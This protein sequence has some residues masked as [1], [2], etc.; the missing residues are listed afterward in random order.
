MLIGYIPSTVISMLSSHI[1]PT[2]L[3]AI[4]NRGILEVRDMPG[5]EQ[6]PT[7]IMLHGL[8]VTGDLNWHKHYELLTKY[9]RVVVYDHHGHGSGI[10]LKKKFTL[11]DAADDVLGVANALEIDKFTPV[12][13]SMGGAVAQLV[14]YRHPERVRGMVLAATSTNFVNGLYG[15]RAFLLLRSFASLAMYSPKIVSDAFVHKVYGRTLP[16]NLDPWVLSQLLNHDW[17]TVAWAGASIGRYDSSTFLDKVT[18]RSAVLV[19]TKDSVVRADDQEHLFALL[20]GDKKMF[21]I[22]GDH[23]SVYTAP[24]VFGPVLLEAC[25]YACA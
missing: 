21:H 12:G 1:G 2:K 15:S 23:Q 7:L 18:T 20:Q 3:I 17:V 24:T 19:T 13:Y 4:P 9:F 10:R 6:G 22:P 11:V 16:S 5:P 14:A 8:G 25:R